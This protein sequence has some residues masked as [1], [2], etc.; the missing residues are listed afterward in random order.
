MRIN[1]IIYI[2]DFMYVLK[3]LSRGKKNSITQLAKDSNTSYTYVFDMIKEFLKKDFIFVK[4]IEKKKRKEISI[5]EKGM[6]V[7]NIINAL[8]EKLDISDED[9]IQWKKN[10]KYTQKDKNIVLEELNNEDI[11]GEEYIIDEEE[12][13][14]NNITY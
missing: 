3:V 11:D 12:E 9:L 14:G 2:P 13:N 1:K 7:V 5:T 4:K 8:M 10:I 6:K